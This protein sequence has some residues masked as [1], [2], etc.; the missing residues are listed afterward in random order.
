MVFG[1]LK[2]T[3]WVSGQELFDHFFVLGKG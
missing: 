3:H 2:L 1:R